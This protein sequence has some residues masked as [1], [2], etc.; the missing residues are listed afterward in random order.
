VQAL[1]TIYRYWAALIFLGVLVQVGAAGY[2]AFYSANKLQDKG[3]TLAF[4]PFDHAWNFHGFFGTVL[5]GAMIVLL[6]L[7]LGARLGRPRIY[8]PLASPSPA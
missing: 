8:W 5:V 3:D 4:K 6:L 7:G 2:G 1:R